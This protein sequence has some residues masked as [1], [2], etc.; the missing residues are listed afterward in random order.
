MKVYRFEN[1]DGDGPYGDEPWMEP[2]L[3]SNMI[4]GKDEANFKTSPWYQTHPT[5]QDDGI[6]VLSLQLRNWQF[7]CGFAS[8]DQARAWFTPKQ[9]RGLTRHGYG[10]KEY[11]IAKDRVALGTHQLLFDTNEAHSPRYV[12]VGEQIGKG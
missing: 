6:D 4:D 7:A 11:E 1:D 9:M 10:M 12:P 2:L 3:C 8:L 5:P